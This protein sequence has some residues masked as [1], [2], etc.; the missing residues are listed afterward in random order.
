MEIDLQD[1]EGEEYRLDELA[2]KPSDQEFFVRYSQ[3]QMTE[4]PVRSLV[5][6]AL[7]LQE[8]CH[9]LRAE[10]DL[11]AWRLNEA[12]WHLTRITRTLALVRRLDFADPEQLAQDAVTVVPAIFS[13]KTAWL[14]L[15]G[16]D[17]RKLEVVRSS[18]PA[19]GRLQVDMTDVESHPLF[20]LLSGRDGVFIVR[21]PLP[22]DDILPGLS[23]E[24]ELMVFPLLNRR[25]EREPVLFGML[26]LAGDSG[27]FFDADTV[28]GSLLA[29]SISAGLRKGYVPNVTPNLIDRRWP[30]GR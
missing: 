27:G 28:I 10:L 3:S 7:M 24:A 25:R 12:E 30:A 19:G 26:I 9:S 5:E 16:L 4:L 23:S 2:S 6:H 8:S 11:T 22:R 29:E 14:F 20:K 17:G 1:Q 18:Q 21:A 15:T 13:A